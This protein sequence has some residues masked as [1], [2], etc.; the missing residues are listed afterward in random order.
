MI[1]VVD[2]CHKEAVMELILVIWIPS[3]W[4][5]I[6]LIVLA[7]LAR[8]GITNKQRIIHYNDVI[9]S[10]MASQITGLT[11]VYSTV[12]S[13]ANERKHQSFASLPFVR[14]IHPWPVNSPHKG[15]VTRKKF[16]FDDVIIFHLF[17]RHHC[18]F[19]TM[20]VCY[21]SDERCFSYWW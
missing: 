20:N 17:L 13:G 19:E 8:D 2:G 16:P 1:K 3:V 6:K 7:W 5:V 14:G 11:I 10:A 21:E 18:N 9:M 15:P 4:H 12:Y